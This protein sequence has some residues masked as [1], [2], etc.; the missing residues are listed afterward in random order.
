M[1]CFPSSRTF[2]SGILGFMLC[3]FVLSSLSLSMSFG[4]SFPLPRCW[5]LGFFLL[6][7]LVFVNS[8][9][10]SCLRVWVE[11]TNFRWN[12][13]LDVDVCFFLTCLSSWRFVSLAIDVG[14]VRFSRWS[15]RKYLNES[16]SLYLAAVHLFSVCL[17]NYL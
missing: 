8:C 11:M 2:W 13:P 4:F 17:K 1:L 7:Q 12:F 15:R 14:L 5:Y 16:Q 10:P 6:S 3:C 9:F